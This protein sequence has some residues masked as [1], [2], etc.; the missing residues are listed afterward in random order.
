MF[1]ERVLTFG[2][3]RQFCPIVC[4]WLEFPNVKHRQF[5]EELAIHGF[6]PPMGSS[7]SYYY[8][9]SVWYARI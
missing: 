4:A 8:Q 6:P 2:N 5:G 3:R 1:R 9:K 7:R